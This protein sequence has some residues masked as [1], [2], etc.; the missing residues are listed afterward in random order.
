MAAHGFSGSD[1]AGLRRRFV[2]LRD[3]EQG[4]VRGVSGE[5]ASCASD[6][7]IVIPELPF[8]NI[9]DVNAIGVPYQG[10]EEQFKIRGEGLLL[11]PSPLL[12]LII[13]TS[14]VDLHPNHNMP[15]AALPHTVSFNTVSALIKQRKNTPY[16]RSEVDSTRVHKPLTQSNIARFVLGLQYLLHL[17]IITSSA[18][19]E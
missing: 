2:E 15:T 9:A 7:C 12:R 14:P 18:S 19:E 5:E 1:A 3:F 16:N 10:G 17:V 11:L 13:I 6:K 4:G 8:D